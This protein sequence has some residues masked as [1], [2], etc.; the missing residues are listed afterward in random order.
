MCPSLGPTLIS[1]TPVPSAAATAGPG[2]LSS[3]QCHWLDQILTLSQCSASERATSM[4]QAEFHATSARTLLQTA[5]A[6]PQDHSAASDTFTIAHAHTC[7][8][9][10]TAPVAG[11]PWASVLVSVVL[12]A[13]ALL[14]CQWAAQATSA[15]IDVSS[16]D[17]PHDYEEV[18]VVVAGHI[19]R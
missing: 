13:A 11:F 6:H 16:E 14:I 4:Q 15:W 8:G 12:L 19:A 7:V 3:N 1:T 18:L 9:Y 17:Q 5:A 10:A 2:V